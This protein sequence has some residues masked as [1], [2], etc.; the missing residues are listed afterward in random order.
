MLLE[1]PGIAGLRAGTAVG[2]LVTMQRI[3]AAVFPMVFAAISAITSMTIGMCVVVGF[4]AVAAII[5]LFTKE[6][7]IGREAAKKRQE[8]KKALSK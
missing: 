1:T 4:A 8:E 3:G 6:T 2:L 7:G 5:F